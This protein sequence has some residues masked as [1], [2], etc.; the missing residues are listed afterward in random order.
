MTPL[1]WWMAPGFTPEEGVFN[2]IEDEVEGVYV[3]NVMG[4]V[5]DGNK[6]IP[7]PLTLGVEREQ[8]VEDAIQQIQ[9]FEECL[10]S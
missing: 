9:V 7:I 10:G 6:F 1:W 3:S 8:V 5:Q 2:G 4:P